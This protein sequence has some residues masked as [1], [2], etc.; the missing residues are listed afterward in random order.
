MN[1]VS[2]TSTIGRTAASLAAPAQD[3]I[4]TAQ[5]IYQAAMLLLPSL[6]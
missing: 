3:A 4:D 6:E 1:I 2:T 5:A